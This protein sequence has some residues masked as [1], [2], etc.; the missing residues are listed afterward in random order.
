MIIGYLA[1][2]LAISGAD[3]KWLVGV[4][5]DQEDPIDTQF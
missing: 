4:K 3:W 5:P 1:G 2:S